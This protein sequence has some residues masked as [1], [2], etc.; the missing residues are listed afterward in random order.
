MVPFQA[1]QMVGQSVDAVC[2]DKKEGEAVRTA[3]HDFEGD[4]TYSEKRRSFALFAAEEKPI[5]AICHGLQLL[6]AVDILA[7]RECT[8]YPACGPEVIRAGG[9]WVDVLGTRI[10]QEEEAPVVGV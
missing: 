10:E 2:P 3:V 6:A 7:G 9:K 4:Q 5:A 8:G 1:L